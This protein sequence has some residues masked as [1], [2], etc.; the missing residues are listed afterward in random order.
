MH[1]GRI[2][3]NTEQCADEWESA[4][5]GSS[6]KSVEFLRLQD[7][8]GFATSIEEKG[9]VFGAILFDWWWNQN[10]FE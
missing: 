1:E 4:E 6:N 7:I 5:M 3:F 10:L 9:R 8:A 2:P